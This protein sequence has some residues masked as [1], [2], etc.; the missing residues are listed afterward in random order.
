MGERPLSTIFFKSYKI[1]RKGFMTKF[2]KFLFGFYGVYLFAV[3]P[4]AHAEN[5]GVDG[6]SQKWHS[7]QR[8]QDIYSQL[9]LTDDQ[10]KKLEVNKHQH[11]AKMEIA[12]QKI[13]TNKEALQQELMK[14]Q[15]DLTK[16]KEIHKQIKFLQS[17]MEDDRFSSI[18]AVRAILTPEQFLKFVNLM[19]KHNQEHD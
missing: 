12:R 11:R 3:L 5:P 19:H 7:R 16:S 10:K 14:A 18:L 13:K 6:S 8:M 15:L 9:N 4:L 2:K 1:I 17:Q